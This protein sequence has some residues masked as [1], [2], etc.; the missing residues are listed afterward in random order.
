MLFSWWMVF[1]TATIHRLFKSIGT[2][3]RH[4][5]N[6][7]S[8]HGRD[9]ALPSLLPL[10]TLLPPLTTVLDR[11]WINIDLCCY[12]SPQP[13]VVIQ[14]KKRWN[15]LS[16]AITKMNHLPQKKKKRT[17][18]KIALRQWWTRI[19]TFKNVNEFDLNWNK[20]SPGIHGESQGAVF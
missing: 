15:E 4:W 12:E 11:Y 13:A 7:T 19:L 3:S 17:V 2:N 9:I 6:T 14:H 16:Y 20:K 8:F 18:F 1:P 10:P 5:P